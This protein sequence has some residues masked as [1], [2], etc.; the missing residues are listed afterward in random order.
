MKALRNV[1]PKIFERVQDDGGL[2]NA[3]SLAIM[4]FLVVESVYKL[5]AVVC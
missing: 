2:D 1:F 5:E 4:T 3:G